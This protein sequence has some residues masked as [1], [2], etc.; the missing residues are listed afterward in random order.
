MH[1]RRPPYR[2]K[3]YT[4]HRW[5]RRR[6]A[7]DD[8]PIPSLPTFSQLHAQPAS[9]GDKR[10]RLSL[11]GCP[12]LFAGRVALS[13]R[14]LHVHWRRALRRDALEPLRLFARHDATCDLDVRHQNFPRRSR[15]RATRAAPRR[16]RLR[17]SEGSAEHV[18]NI[19]LGREH[20][21]GNICYSVELCCS[22]SRVLDRFSYTSTS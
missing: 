2:T 5:R 13:R 6:Q 14:C 18:R 7:S 8:I 9:G 10:M 4:R 3:N 1:T 12:S 17:I 19:C 15:A 21:E 22:Q 20:S 16:I 11:R